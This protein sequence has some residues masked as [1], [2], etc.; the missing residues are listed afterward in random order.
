MFINI[1][2]T[3]E[4][5]ICLAL[6]V[7]VL[8]VL[9]AQK[10]ILTLRYREINRKQTKAQINIQFSSLYDKLDLYNTNNTH[11]HLNF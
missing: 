7:H 9:M 11:L 1:Y 6:P 3:L 4:G 8:M 5:Q 2:R 10:F